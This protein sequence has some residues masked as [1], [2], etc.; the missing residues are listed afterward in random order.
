MA[1]VGALFVAIVPIPVRDRRPDSQNPSLTA[2]FRALLADRVLGTVTAASSLGQLG[3]GAL[4]VVAAVLASRQ[5]QPAAPGWLMAAVAGGA[6]RAQPSYFSSQAPRCYAARS[7][8]DAG[9][10]VRS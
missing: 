2:G 7:A 10:Y 5:D 4:P 3:L 6:C 1:A 8:P 9:I